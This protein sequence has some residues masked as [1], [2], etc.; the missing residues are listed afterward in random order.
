MSSRWVALVVLFI[1]RM[2]MAFQFQTLGSSGPLLIRDLGLSYADVGTLIGLYLL[3]GIVIALPG[4]LLGQ[5]Y[6]SQVVLAGL[7]VMAIGGAG[8]ALAD[9][10]GALALWRVVG[11]VGAVLLNVLLARMVADWFSDEAL[12][13]AMAILVTSWPL[14]VGVG[15]AVGHPLA[16]AAG[17]PALMWTGAGLCLAGLVLMALLYRD[18]PRAADEPMPQARLSLRE[19][20]MT[21]VA[22]GIWAVYNAGFIIL[23]SFA[24]EFFVTRGYS[25]AQGS[26]IVSLLGWFLVP[27][28]IAGGYI[29]GRAA[30]PDW[31][32]AS[33]FGAA[34]VAAAALP[35]SS[36]P[37]VLFLLVA[38]AAGLPAGPIMTLPVEASRP[39][40]RATA[41]G[42]YFSC[43]YAG[44]AL[45][46]ALAG[47]LRDRMGSASAPVLFA[48]GTM[49][50]ALALLLLFR[51]LQ[52]R[53]AI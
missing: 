21:L 23:I 40:N 8:T 31:V 45:F 30:R 42:V 17:W 46:P 5:R 15:L 7:A 34:A 19:L 24:P 36:D 9:G 26:W 28:I 25:P 52:R 10:M 1:A 41:M 13:A 27:M 16:T 11:G 4:G 38:L 32:M 20:R 47:W 37:L 29:A 44:M 12:P 35:A 43:Y 51:L 2:A 50:V 49:G 39:E 6:G 53:A 3:P 33:G 14:G 48:A 18:P 22:G